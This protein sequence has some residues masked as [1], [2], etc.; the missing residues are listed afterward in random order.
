MPKKKQH[1]KKQPKH[2]PKKINPVPQQRSN[3]LPKK[4]SKQLRA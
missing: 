1:H 4:G 3:T 2:Q